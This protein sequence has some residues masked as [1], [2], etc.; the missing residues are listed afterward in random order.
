MKNRI[1]L[2]LAFCI[3]HIS[4]RAQLGVIGTEAGIGVAGHTGDGGLASLAQISFPHGITRSVVSG[5]IYFSENGTNCHYIRMIDPSTGLIS[6]VA[7]IGTHG[8]SGDGGL[9]TA[10]G[11]NHPFDMVIDVNENIYFTDEKNNRVRMIDN[12]TGIISTIAG[13][14]VAANGADG[15]AT[16]SDVNNPSGIAMDA[17]GNLFISE[18]HRV[19]KIDLS[20]G[21]I[22]TIGGSASVSYT[23]DGGPVSAAGFSFNNFL[24]FDNYGNLLVTDN[25]NHCIRKIDAVGGVI[26]PSCIINTIVGTGIAGAGGDGGVATSAELFFPGTALVNATDYMFVLD[27]ENNK[28]RGVDPSTNIINTVGAT[29]VPG[30]SG[31]GGPA[32]LAQFNTPRDMAI[33][34]QGN[35]YITDA[36]NHRVRSIF[37]G[38]KP[39]FVCEGSCIPL[40]CTPGVS[41]S[42]LPV[43]DLSDPLVQNPVA[44][45]SATT[46]YTVTITD[47]S[48]GTTIET[49]M[50]VVNPLPAAI[51]GA[52]STPCA[53]SAVALSSSTPGGNWYSA[54][55]SIAVVDGVTGIVTGMSGGTAL[56]SYMLPTG[57]LTTTNVTFSGVIEGNN[58]VCQGST[59]ALSG[60]PSGG[61]WSSSNTAIAT[62]SASGVVGGGGYRQCIAGY[63]HYYLCSCWV[64]TERSSNGWCTVF[65][66][67]SRCTSTFSFTGAN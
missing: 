67:Y 33:D 13:T 42:W 47:A 35:Y 1:L 12:A 4:T 22:S 66:T 2:L 5:K 32:V 16:S 43:T 25:G 63:C 46:E 37:K 7:G 52:G 56:I 9:A 48:G 49:V 20:T 10:A 41:Y 62:V 57:C 27:N 34:N 14:G 51:T 29:G 39:Y 21:L 24:N 44:C 55:L 19:R 11:L 23:G 58:S 15:T 36:Q 60:T 17:A 31:D 59:I 40:A 65:G 6:T 18:R 3:I 8:Y 53:G 61:T 64:Y 28:V 38:P 50:V 30:Y 45:P 54:D 26:T